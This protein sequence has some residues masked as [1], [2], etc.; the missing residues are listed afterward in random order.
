[1]SEERIGR[2]VRA[3]VDGFPDPS[4]GFRQ[5]VLARVP[6]DRV[7]PGRRW[8][9]LVAAALAIA[10]IATLVLVS[11]GIL[12]RG[13]PLVTPSPAPTKTASPA[14][15]VGGA[16]QAPEST[17]VLAFLDATTPNQV[18]AITWDGVGP[19]RLTLTSPVG[20]AIFAQSP[21]GARFRSDANVFNRAGQPQ[22]SV[23]TAT[24]LSAIWAD[25]SRHVCQMVGAN[26]QSTGPT[27]FQLVQPGNPPRDVA[28]LGQVLGQ[29]APSVLACSVLSDRAVVAQ[30]GLMGSSTE[31]WVLRLS[32][33]AVLY[34]SSFPTGSA[35]VALVASRDGQYLAETASACCATGPPSTTIHRAADGAL[36]GRLDG[37]RVVG[38]SWDSELAITTDDAGGST[39]RLV[40]WGSGQ[41]V[42]SAP[43]GTRLRG[44]A[45]E[46]GGRR[47]AIAA[48][49]GSGTA[50]RA[51]NI[52]VVS[53]DGRATS[54]ILGIW[55]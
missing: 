30:G 5:R 8:G 27:T 37:R 40:R 29:T 24:K 41:V 47:V 2:E 50:S 1:M 48:G 13:H 43:T 16:L 31:V 6:D 32:T 14:A 11:R 28:S 17:P 53:P 39:P 55:M 3:M 4:P 34:H 49:S 35:G 18:D 21:D 38:F 52:W 7:Q 23:G 51:S 26:G 20:A 33:G 44:F 22:G 54:P 15:V 25:D 45:S 36:V 42:W 9:A 19:G 10:L 46:P 12:S